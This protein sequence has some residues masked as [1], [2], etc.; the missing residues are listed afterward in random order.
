MR[1]A[2][3]PRPQRADTM[4]QRG[5]LCLVVG[6]SGV[7]KDSLLAAAARALPSEFVFPR[8]F[9]TR[10]GGDSTEAH[11]PVAIDR[12]EALVR[13]GAFT[14]HWGAHGLRY[15]LPVEIEADLA[16]G[17]CVVANVSRGVLDEARR[18]LQPVAVLSIEA[19]EATLRERLGARGREE[20]AEIEGRIARAA[21]FTVTGEDVIRVRN[22]GALEDAVRDFVG[23][24]RRLAL[25]GERS[26]QR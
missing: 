10:P 5:V 2:T 18:R 12:F 6:P 3:L 7:G 26:A 17:R 16:R 24:L 11:V 9:I 15:G 21:A 25:E 13:A 8:R 22:D 20:A 19:S 14:L 1:K 23:A 4:A